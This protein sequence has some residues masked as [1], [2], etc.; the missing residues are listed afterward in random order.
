MILTP[1]ILEYMR[2]YPEMNAVLVTEGRL[3]D[4]VGQR[5]DAG[6]RLAEIVPQDMISV[7]IGGGQRMLVVGSSGPTGIRLWCGEVSR[8]GRDCIGGTG[9]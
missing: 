8:P 9:T 4:V 2:R 3:V 1:I 5:F 6:I 7:P